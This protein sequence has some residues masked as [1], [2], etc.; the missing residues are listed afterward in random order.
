MTM[1]S[2][3][4]TTIDYILHVTQTVIFM[5]HTFGGVGLNSFPHVLRPDIPPLLQLVN[6]GVEFI[7]VH[8]AD[9]VFFSKHG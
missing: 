5:T 4:N 6:V 9:F 2:L 1:I 3:T 7:D 8:F